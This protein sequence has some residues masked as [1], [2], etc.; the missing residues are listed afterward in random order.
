MHRVSDVPVILFNPYLTCN[1]CQGY[2]IDATTIVEC[3]HS[4]CRSCI[5]TYLKLNTTC[6]VCATLLHKT[7]PHCAIRPDRALQ[8]IVY[9]LIPNLFEKEMLCRRKFY[10][11]EYLCSKCLLNFKQIS[12]FRLCWLDVWPYSVLPYVLLGILWCIII[13]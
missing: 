9:K 1:L 2:L 3:L 12:T 11:G 8:S 4:F 13:S 5:L 6:P 10:E 7:K